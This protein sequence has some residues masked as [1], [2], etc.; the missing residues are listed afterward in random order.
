MES[1]IVLLALMSLGVQTILT[2]PNLPSFITPD[3]LK[4]LEEKFNIDTISNVE[5][6]IAT[7]IN[8][9]KLA[10]NVTAIVNYLMIDMIGEQEYASK[11]F[12]N[13]N[14]IIKQ[15]KPKQTI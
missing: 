1:K 2:G 5:N 7:L 9:W 4:V 13:I 8:K 10:Q 3:V 15:E 11:P 6:D 12:I 14:Q